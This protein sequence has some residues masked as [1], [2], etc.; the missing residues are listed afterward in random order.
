MARISIAIAVR[1]AGS[2]RPPLLPARTA[3][4]L[5][6]SRRSSDVESAASA[7]PS[8]PWASSSERAYCSERR[9][10]PR[11]FIASAATAGSSDALTI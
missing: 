7:L 2:E 1:A 4:S 9:V 3:T 5:A 11:R 10:S 6:R 8:R